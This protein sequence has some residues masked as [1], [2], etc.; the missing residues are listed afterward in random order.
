MNCV[1]LV[2]PDRAEIWVPTQDPEGAQLAMSKTLGLPMDKCF[3][4]RYDP[5]GG[6]GRRARVSDYVV[7]AVDIA[8]KMPGV[9]IKMIWTREED[10]THGQY[11][12]ITQA[13]LS[14]GL[15]SNNQLT[16]LHMRISGQSIYAWRNPTANMEGFKDELQVQGLYGD[17]NSDQQLCYKT[18][19][20]S[21][22]WGDA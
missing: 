19:N 1:A 20:M 6:F 9:P 4:N 7:N 18:P 17:P 3:V 22:E 11:R 10:M 2:T 12:P 5:G 15:D 16:G 21:V 13:K 8:R 14:A